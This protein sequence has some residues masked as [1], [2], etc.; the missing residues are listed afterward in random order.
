MDPELE[1]SLL[2]SE[3]EGAVTRRSFAYGALGVLLAGGIATRLAGY[4]PPSPVLPG[5]AVIQLPSMTEAEAEA[6][7]AGP[8]FSTVDR[9]A[10]LADLRRRRTHLVRMPVFGIDNGIGAAVRVDC[11]LLLRTVL[12]AAEPTV[13]ILPIQR[14]GR[15]GITP[16]PPARDV[17]AG[18]IQTT[19]PT[20]LPPIP[21]GDTLVL[22]VIV[23]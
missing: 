12:L 6:A 5:L 23:Q 4:R 16:T 11:G 15:V 9:P 14:A 21:A 17:T 13:V 10:L 3:P 19:G 18:I 22:N 1:Q 20:P 7:L 2:Q 8:D